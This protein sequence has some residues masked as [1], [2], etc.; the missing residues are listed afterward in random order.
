MILEKMSLKGKVGIVTGASRGLGKGIAIGLVQ[1][2]ADLAVT[3]RDIEKIE[4]VAEEIKN[5]GGEVLPLQ[6]D[7]SRKE[8]IDRMLEKT[9]EKFGKIDFLFNNAGRITRV[10]SEDFSERDWDKEININLK[11]TFLCCQAVGRVMIKQK[12]GKIINISSIASFIGGKN[13]SAYVASKGGVSQLTK[14][15]ASDWAKYN[16]R[17]NAIGPGY[18]TTDLTE[19]LRQDPERFS[20]IN[21]RIPLGR[22]GKPEDLAGIA[23]FLACDASDYITGQTIFVDGGWLAV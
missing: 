1:A 21:A 15:L 3:S 5:W 8:D 16:I 13:I 10:P 9:L 20:A 18:F 19:P 4:K 7:V 2:G 22:W 23:V 14:S 17:V 11:G 6:V 12:R